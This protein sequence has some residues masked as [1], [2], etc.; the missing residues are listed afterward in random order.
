MAGLARRRPR[1]LGKVDT[2]AISHK[3]NDAKLP[4]MVIIFFISLII[5][6]IIN[7][8]PLRL[9]VYRIAL[10]VVFL[11]AVFTWATGKAGPIRTVDILVFLMMFWMAIAT[12][13]HSGVGESIESI[14]ILTLEHVGAYLIGRAYIRNATDFYKVARLLVVICLILLPLGIYEALTT[15]NITL[16][17]WDILGR[18]PP[19][20]YKEPRLGLDRAQG[21]F[22]HPILFGVFPI[23]AVGA[24]AFIVAYYRGFISK[25]LL[26]AVMFFTGFLS[27]S[28]GPISALVVQ[29]GLIFWQGIFRNVKHRWWILIGLLVVCY[30]VVDILSNRTPIVV[31]IS[32]LALNTHT[33]YNRVNIWHW[34]W[35]NIFDNPIFGVGLG[36]DWERYWFMSPSFDMFWLLYP[37]SYGIIAGI[38]LMGA[39][40]VLVTQMVR[41]DIQNPRV[42]SFRTGWIISLVGIT[43]A[44]WMVHFWNA[45]LALY[46]F[47][48]GSGVWFVGYQ[49]SDEATS[50]EEPE[51]VPPV[52]SR[53]T[54]FPQGQEPD[55]L[56]RRR[57]L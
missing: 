57:S 53:Y 44:G 19:D 28:S 52:A 13:Y 33:A 54:R 7:L 39:P 2:A 23:P 45:P 25:A 17:L 14:G 15:T 4:L 10:L 56:R 31:A 38:G 41:K 3:V 29:I 9:S 27:V 51:A 42:S 40:I 46:F 16:K 34:G 30:V 5:P 47:F 18:V 20:V 22:D 32:Y 6:L 8:G 37:M 21:P 26:T 11:P 55:P 35:S 24:A 36:G 12:L 48:L 43:M 1:T 50:K 49:D